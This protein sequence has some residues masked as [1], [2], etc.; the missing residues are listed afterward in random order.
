MTSKKHTPLISII[1]PAYNAEHFITDAIDSVLEQTYA[2]WEMI[3]V[4]DCSTDNTVEKIELSMKQ[5]DRISFFGLT[6]NL[7]SAIARNT[8]INMAKGRYIAFLDSDDIWFPEKLEKQL[9][10]MQ[11]NNIAFSFTEYMRIKGDGTELNANIKAPRSIG[12]EGLLKHCVI[13][14][15]TV[16]LDKEKIGKVHMIELRARQ[17]Y[18]L[19]LNIT[20]QGFLAYGIPEVLAK[21]R[22]G[23]SSISSNKLKML[24]I[25]WN[26][27]RRIEKQGFVK[28]A[29]CLLNYVFAYTGRFFRGKKVKEREN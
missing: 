1:T 16:M 14:C 3:I 28:S 11:E 2:H 27:Y 25:N 24:R 9:R 20:K 21:Y 6:E 13:G 5:D 4:D 26:V 12:Y 29:W 18:V 10:F 8:A 23:K 17:D 22:V 19:W 15:L 7:G